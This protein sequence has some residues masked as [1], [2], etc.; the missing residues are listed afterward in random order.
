MPDEQLPSLQT[1]PLELQLNVAEHL[2]YGSLL[3]LRRTNRHFHEFFGRLKH[4]ELEKSKFV[5]AA[6]QYPRHVNNFGCYRC[7]RIL[8]A[9]KFARKQIKKSYGKGNTK[10][11]SRFCVECGVK[12]GIYSPGSRVD[13]DGVDMIYC[14]EC[15]RIREVRFCSHCGRCA[16]CLGL[17]VSETGNESAAKDA[18]LRFRIGNYTVPANEACPSCR[19]QT[20]QGNGRAGTIILTKCKSS[21]WYGARQNSSDFDKIAS[22]E[23]FDDDD[24]FFYDD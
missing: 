12:K 3:A 22:P 24:V 8:P 5:R 15:R 20:I 23:E 1:L 21:K 10:S 11:F 19:H 16:S 6:E 9:S 13:K 14:R 18:V 17:S 4:P 2:D 7:F